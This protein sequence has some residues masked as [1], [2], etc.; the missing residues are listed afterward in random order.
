MSADL[1]TADLAVSI[2]DRIASGES[3]RSICRAEGM[4]SE[5]TVRRWATDDRDGLGPRL[6]P[7]EPSRLMPCM[8]RY[9]TLPA[10]AVMRP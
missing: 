3:L 7:P 1:F 4:P 2:C 5:V 10:P 9:W 6:P 8:T